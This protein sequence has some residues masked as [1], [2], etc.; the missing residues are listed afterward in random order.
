MRV[1][2]CDVCTDF[3]NVIKVDDVDNSDDKARLERQKSPE[4]TTD[5]QDMTKFY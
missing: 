3:T 5:T 1:G 4:T 2:C